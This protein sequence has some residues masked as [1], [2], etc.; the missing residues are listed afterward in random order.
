MK[1]VA[2]ILTYNKKVLAFRRPY[3]KNNSHISLKY[4]FPGGKIKKNETKVTALKRELHEELNLNIS[5]FNE[6]YFTSHDYIK[7]KVDI[8]FYIA[9]LYYLNFKLN[10]H[11]EY[12]IICIEDLKELDW[13]QA[14]Y[15]V[16][17]YM[18]KN[19]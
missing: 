19:G 8:S 7:Y 16:I 2:A 12:K 9:N 10:F 6:Y 14:D 18:Q 3:I 11:I 13:L 5:N 4:E 17:D 1:V 15:S